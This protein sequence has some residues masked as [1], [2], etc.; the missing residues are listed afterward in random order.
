[1]ALSSASAV[2]GAQLHPATAANF[3]DVVRLMNC[4]YS[5]FIED[6]STRPR[7]IARADD[8]DEDEAR[9]NQQIEAAAHV[10]LREKIDCLAAEDRLPEPASRSFIRWLHAGFYSGAPEATLIV[11]S[12]HAVCR[13]A[14]GEWRAA[15][16]HDFAV[17]RHI[18]SSS[19]AI[20]PFTAH[21]EQRYRFGELGPATRILAAAAA[22]HRLNYIHPFP[23]GKS[24]LKLPDIL[25]IDPAIV[26]V[27][28]RYSCGVCEGIIIQVPAPARPWTT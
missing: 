25:Q 27:R 4:Y 5:N 20:E 13:M 19:Q 10:S 23:D 14:P 22:Y 16:E 12:A 7:D 21:F 6:H 15:T 18:P 3:S 1:M 17:G 9:R 11:R 28:P 26:T 24:R 2:L 8:L